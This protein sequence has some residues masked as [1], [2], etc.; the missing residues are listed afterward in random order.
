[1][2]CVKQT[3]MNHGEFVLVGGGMNLR[4]DQKDRSEIKQ[5][6]NTCTL[7][8]HWTIMKYFQLNE[9]HNVSK[10]RPRSISF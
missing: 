2:N 5:L 3:D 10:C 4:R 1:M 9:S 6:K 8:C 7:R